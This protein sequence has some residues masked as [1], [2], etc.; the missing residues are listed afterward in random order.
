M[1]DPEH[2]LEVRLP[3]ENGKNKKK[4]TYGITNTPQRRMLSGCVSHLYPSEI[5]KTH[6][7]VLRDMMMGEGVPW[8]KSP[9]VGWDGMSRP[10]EIEFAMFR[11]SLHE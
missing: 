11:P 6:Q 2:T 7:S 8:R 1:I 10:A 5:L 4:K 9:R 3:Q